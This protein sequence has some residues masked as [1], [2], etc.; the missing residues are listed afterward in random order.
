MSIQKYVPV[1]GNGPFTADQRIQ[2]EIPKSA[3]VLD[4]SKATLV[5][6]IQLTGVT[7]GTAG[8][9][10]AFAMDD[11]A[12]DLIRE[13]RVQT[14]AGKVLDELQNVN[15][16]ACA[17]NSFLNDDG[18]MSG[19]RVVELAGRD[20]ITKSQTTGT[21][22]SYPQLK[23]TMPMQKTS[24]GVFDIDQYPAFSEGLRAEILLDEASVP[25]SQHLVNRRYSCSNLSGAGATSATLSEI[26]RDPFFAVG[27]SVVVRY[28]DAPTAKYET[29][30][31]TSLD[32]SGKFPVVSFSALANTTASTAV[33]IMQAGVI[34]TSPSVDATTFTVPGK[35]ADSPL[36][37]DMAIEVLNKNGATVEA[38][39]TRIANLVQNADDFT[40]TIADA[41]QTANATSLGIRQL[42][43][44]NPVW[45][46][47]DLSL[48]I[49]TTTADAK[50]MK[51]MTKSSMQFPVKTFIN[52]REMVQPSL[53]SELNLP[54]TDFMAAARAIMS[55]P[56]DMSTSDAEG[57]L[58]GCRDFFRRYQFLIDGRSA[59]L[60]PVNTGVSI[61]PYHL[62]MIA[63]AFSQCGEDIR[64]VS[65]DYMMWAKPL[66]ALG[67]SSNLL[68]KRV[69]L[70]FER[71]SIAS[72]VGVMVNHFVCADKVIS[73]GARA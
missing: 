59:P 54:V 40:V 58:R 52:L 23:F 11:G 20:L 57:R 26:C 37:I 13:C 56:V 41:I 43:A 8:S 17:K 42:P 48:E 70:R 30:T 39:E 24:L 53:F 32:Y 50:M 55:I 25:L 71:T 64:K 60:Q 65:P 3:G 10:A 5:G 14:S 35:I 45:Q 1:E 63:E 72:A 12:V 6:K 18:T 44:S 67:A 19:R 51:Q 33:S 22:S 28:T 61:A 21:A 27:D 49:P 68:G 36:Y 2:W 73:L 38:K 7:P 15:V 62:S 69:A 9:F 31:I 66:S 4:L 29:K 46:L 34:P 16:L 47:T